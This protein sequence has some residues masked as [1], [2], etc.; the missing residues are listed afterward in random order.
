MPANAVDLYRYCY[1]LLLLLLLLLLA[2]LLACLLLTTS[3]SFEWLDGS[4][5]AQT[6]ERA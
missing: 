4:K 6:K 5:K 1:W 2:Y 3:G